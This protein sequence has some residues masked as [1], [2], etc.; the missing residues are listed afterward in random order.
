MGVSGCQ[1]VG[2]CA[3]LWQWPFKAPAP[4]GAPLSELR[5]HPQ[6]CASVSYRHVTC[7]VMSSVSYSPARVLRIAKL[8]HVVRPTAFEGVR[9]G[10]L[11][12]RLANLG[13]VVIR[14]TDY[15][16]LWRYRVR[17]AA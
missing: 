15:L 1:T 4:F 3:R 5:P 2:V 9:V 7:H 12:L 13:R 14:L 6:A 11:V 16:R 8:E 10:R 17:L